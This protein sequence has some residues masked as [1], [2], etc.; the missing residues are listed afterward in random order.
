MFRVS[1]FVFC[2]RFK[3]RVRFFDG[4]NPC[5]NLSCDSAYVG[6]TNQ[7]LSTRIRQYIP[8]KVENTLGSSAKPSDPPSSSI[9]EHLV[10]NPNC[11]KNFCRQM[12]TVICH[13]Q[14]FF[15]LQALEA[16]N[17]SI[18][19]PVLCQQKKFV[20]SLLFKHLGSGL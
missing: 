9:A 3:L 2:L 14:T 11:G 8:L 5:W 18:R 12:F 15:H 16:L 20:H 19:K 4:I 10:N 6:R 17:I 7:P 13:G 1:L